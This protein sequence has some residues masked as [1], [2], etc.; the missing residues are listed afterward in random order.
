MKK[1]AFSLERML[2]FQSQN[3][4][5]EMGIL[6]RMTAERDALEAPKRDMADKAAGVQADIT[7]REAE[8]TTIFMLKACFSILES[9]RNQLEEMEEELKLLQAG[10]ERQ[11]QIVTEASREVKKLEKLKEKQLEEY[12]RGEAKEQ[13][14]TI[15]EHVAGNFVR[16][17]ASQ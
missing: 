14:E 17:G 9:A 11:R 4:E 1:F 16:R 12:H 2:N 7:R 6:G 8:G 15:A 3:L 5:K 10:L 13:Q